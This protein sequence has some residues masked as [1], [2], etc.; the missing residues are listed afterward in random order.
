MSKASQR[1]AVARYRTRLDERGLGR[2]EVIGLDEDR[3]LIR[4]L[5]KRL[6]A[7]DAEAARLRATVRR[8]VHPKPEK[9]GILAALR[10]SP[11]VGAELELTREQ[12]G[13]R[14]LDL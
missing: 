3:S 2:Y 7:N 10:R 11:L 6:A 8:H 4:A 12:V 13:E 9:G 1:H 14:D 5:A